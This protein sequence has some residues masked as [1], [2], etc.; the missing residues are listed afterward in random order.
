MVLL[1]KQLFSFLTYRDRR[2]GRAIRG[3]E[4]VPNFNFLDRQLVFW[5]AERDLLAKK[6]LRSY[7]N[8][9][10]VRKQIISSYH[11][12][13]YDIT[14]N[15]EIINKFKPVTIVGYP[16]ALHF[17]ALE[18]RKNKIQ[19]SHYPKGII[20]AGE[21]LQLHQKD[22]IEDVFKSRIFNRYGCR[23][24]GHIANECS[25]H[26]GFHYNADDLIIEVVNDK[27]KECKE[28]EIGNLLITDLNNYAFPMIRYQIGDLGSISDMSDCKCGCTLPKLKTIEGRAF[29]IIHGKNGNKVSGPF[30]TLT[31]RYKVKGIEAFQ[32]RQSSNFNLQINV[33]TNQHFNAVEK[34]K[35]KQ[36]IW[37]KL[38]EG[39]VIEIYEVAEFEYTKTGKFKWITSELNN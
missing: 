32:I 26:N 11:L 22:L 20:S 9:Y 36:L 24:V 35:T 1:G 23:E 14:T 17:M 31:F 15:V 5:G 37:E 38:G 13:E 8:K 29:D 28:G 16:S 6:S 12:T 39:I 30:W 25:E 3:D 10:I 2:E 18:I 7:F 4:F 19:L 33:M 27:G 34:E 21:T